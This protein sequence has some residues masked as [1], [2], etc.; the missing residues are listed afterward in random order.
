MTLISF[1]ILLCSIVVASAKVL[2]DSIC[3]PYP[4]CKQK[5]EMDSW[6]HPYYENEPHAP[7]LNNTIREYVDD[8]KLV[9]FE[10]E[11][12]HFEASKSTFH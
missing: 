2:P 6:F 1:A 5:E 7:C 8:T 10:F 9:N 3:F 12:I 11:N 4:D